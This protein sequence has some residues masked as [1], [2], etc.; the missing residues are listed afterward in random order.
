MAS[1]VVTALIAAVPWPFQPAIWPSLVAKMKRAAAGSAAPTF[2]LKSA[3]EPLKTIP[4]GAPGTV[5]VRPSFAPVVPLYSVDLLVPLSE[6]HHGDVPLATIPQPLTRSVSW[7]A[8]APATSD[9]S[10]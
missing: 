2:T 9:H 1:G 8:A 10:L 6:T 4:V 5:T 7:P 3:A